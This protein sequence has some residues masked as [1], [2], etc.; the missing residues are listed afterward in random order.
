MKCYSPL[1]YSQYIGGNMRIN[2]LSGFIVSLALFVPFISNA[3][4]VNLANQTADLGFS[5][6]AGAG[7]LVVNAISEAQTSIDVAAL[8]ITSEGIYTALV[9]AHNRGVNVR[10]VVDANSAN[11]PGSDVQALIDQNIP[12]KLNSEFRIMHNKYIVIDGNSVQTGSFNY[13]SNADKKNAEN[14]IFLNEQPDIAKLYSDNFERLFADSN[15][16]NNINELQ[17]KAGFLSE[18][19]LRESEFSI[20]EMLKKSSTNFSTF[21]L[22]DG[23]VDVAFSDA[24]NYIPSS[25]SAKN[26][27]LQVIRNAKN[28]IYMAAYGFS[29]PDI[30]SALKDSQ[31]SGVNINI[32]LDYKSNNRNS[33]VDDLRSL[34]SNIYLN[35]KFSIMHNKYIV[36]DSNTLELGSFNYTT[37]AETQQCNNI[38][39][40]Y[41]QTTL[42][43][44]Y[45]NDW[46]MLYQTSMK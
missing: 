33:S 26:L 45:L 22:K 1:L 46:N 18:Y 30:I 27:V 4:T 31:K 7:N 20:E 42:I 15:S 34:G 2:R 37:S 43:N 44:N 35:K 8:L 21:R 38:L 40:F 19:L 6:N 24:C 17:T 12:V 3:K 25:P 29:D 16:I 41:N 36:A 32:V 9:D 28:N 10:I 13:S 39:V 23:V 11:T 5:P 14:A